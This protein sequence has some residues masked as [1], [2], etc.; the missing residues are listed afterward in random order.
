LYIINHRL[1][2]RSLTPLTLLTLTLA[3]LNNLPTAELSSPINV[4]ASPT[5]VTAPPIKVTAA[6]NCGRD[7]VTLVKIYTEESKYSRENNNFN[8]KLIIFNDLYNRVGI[9]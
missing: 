2:S 7:L 1:K 8:R 6:V 3:V 4:T 5:N 9:L